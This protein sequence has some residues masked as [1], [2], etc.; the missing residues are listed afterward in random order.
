MDFEKEIK[1]WEVLMATYQPID[2]EECILEVTMEEIAKKF[3]V[4]VNKLRIKK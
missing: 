2:A 1:L 3:G 4:D